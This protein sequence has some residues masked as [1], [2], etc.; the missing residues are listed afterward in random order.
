MSTPNDPHDPNGAVPVTD[1]T[2]SG[3]T[4]APGPDATAPSA[5]T[6]RADAAADRPAG[7]LERMYNGEGGFAFVGHRRRWFTIFGIVVVACLVTILVRGFSLG[8][9]FEGGTRMT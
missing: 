5:D 3:T 1:P 8:I 2:S 9:D 4:T 6:A 7:F